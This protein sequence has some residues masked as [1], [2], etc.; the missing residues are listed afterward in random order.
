M[1]DDK[2]VA[3]FLSQFDDVASELASD[4][5]MSILGAMPHCDER[6]YHG[7]N[8][9]GYHDPDLGYICAIFPSESTIRVAFEHGHLLPDPQGLLTGG[10]KQVRYLEISE[11]SQRFAEQLSDLIDQALAL[12]QPRS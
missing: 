2:E 10:G 7:W 9:L 12:G 6:I 11:W 5:R 4:A 1:P 3:D 8:G